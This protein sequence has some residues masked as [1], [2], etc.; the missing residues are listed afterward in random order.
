MVC[1][2]WIVG[3][4]VVALRAG[5]VTTWAVRVSV[6]SP[7]LDMPGALARALA[8]VLAGGHERIRGLLAALGFEPGL[9]L[10]DFL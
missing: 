4:C 8:V 9:M 7:Q 3:C 6:S 2:L 5:T 1:K 10:F